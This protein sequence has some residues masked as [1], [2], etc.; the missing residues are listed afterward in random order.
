MENS[1]ESGSISRRNFMKLAAAVSA[2]LNMDWTLPA[3]W[4]GPV[5]TDQPVVVIG[6]GLGGLSA[7]AVLA[8]NGFPV[9]VVEQHEKPGGYATSF[10]RGAGSYT[11]E[12]S[13]HATGSPSKGLKPILEAA[14]IA[15]K[16]KIVKLPEKLR[17]KTPDYDLKWTENG[18]DGVAEEMSRMFPGEA[19]GIRGFFKEI[20]GM[21]DELSIPFDTDSEQGR[22]SFPETHKRLWAIRDKTLAQVLDGF[23]RDE[24]AR[25]LITYNWPYYGLPP[26]TLSG[27]YFC[28]ATA[29]YLHDGSHYVKTRSQDLSDALSNAIQAAGGEVIL[30]TRA[31]A[32]ITEGK[33]I[34]GVRLSDERSIPACAVVSNASVPRTVEM[35]AAGVLPAHYLEKLKGYRPS[36]SSF[37]VFLGLKG[38]IRQKIDVGEAL[39]IRQYDTDRTYEGLL[40]CDPLRSSLRVTVYDNFYEGYSKPGTSTISLNMLSGY[41]PWRRFEAD[42]FAGRKDEYRKEKERIANLMIDEAERLFMPGLRSMIEV[43]EA[44]TPLTNVRYTGNPEGAIYGY[45]QSLDNA[46]MNRL[47]VRA[48]LT[49][50]YFASA[51]SSPGGGYEPCL[52]SGLTASRALMQDFPARA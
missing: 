35:L 24:K 9:T 47:D 25:S 39:F 43:C 37:Q 18:I 8:R 2:G 13:L 34:T 12:V 11:F 4:A 51:W 29:S 40:A 17:I 10:D 28:V 46:F 19:A 33:Q 1:Y 50:L 16:V 14:G 7:G 52:A 5:R 6:A 48:P 26:S 30:E 44:A 27:F 31:E 21:L 32:I 45:Q 22:A 42:Y 36:L 20:S 23:V 15:D 49:G 38:D 3:A 41:E